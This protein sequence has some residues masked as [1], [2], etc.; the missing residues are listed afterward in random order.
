MFIEYLKTVAG[1]AAI[2]FILAAVGY[3]L[4]KTNLIQKNAVGSL[5]NVLLWAC[6]PAVII[7]AFSSG[8]NA[9][10]ARSLLI[11][12]LASIIVI[13]L[14]TAIAGAAFSRR[15]DGERAILNAC[16]TF[17]NVGF[18]CLP[19]VQAFYGNEGVMYCSIFVAVFNIIFWT[20]GYS[21]LSGNGASVVKLIVNPG[22]LA[23]AIALPLFFF[24]VSLPQIVFD[25]ID[26]LATM[27]TPLAMVTIGAQLAFAPL[28]VAFAEGDVYAVSFLKLLLV[29]VLVAG[30][31]WLIPVPLNATA[32][33]VL[34]I[35]AGAPTATVVALAAP[36][37]GKNSGLAGRCVAMTTLFSILTLP[38]CALLSN[39]LF[40]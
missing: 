33:A 3:I 25:S 36:N 40:G 38:L 1:Q 10:L 22:I 21:M 29:P 39:R 27:Q 20:Y 23:L 28:L 14:S 32:K 24:N 37:S 5:T 19:I 35:E 9:G 26:A 13:G 34:V 31:L 16:V 2:M 30:L 12:A 6:V 17:A 4:G 15:G 7:Q 8:F 11:F 18:M